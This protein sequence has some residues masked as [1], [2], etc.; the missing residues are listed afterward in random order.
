MEGQS[1]RWTGL[2]LAGVLLGPPAVMS[3]YLGLSR[4]PTRWFTTGT[5]GAALAV[6]V[7]AGLACIA[8]L[9]VPA[10]ARV[11]LALVY[12]PAAGLALVLYALYFV[13][14]VFGDWL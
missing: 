12:V 5:D 11:M 14:V 10:T 1:G 3:L 13:G 4:W 9:P 2:L 8:R 6:A 7:V